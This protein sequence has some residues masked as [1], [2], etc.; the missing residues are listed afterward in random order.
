MT[1]VTQKKKDKYE[2]LLKKGKKKKIK[3]KSKTYP[4]GGRTVRQ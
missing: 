2:E 4:S 1:K 3:I